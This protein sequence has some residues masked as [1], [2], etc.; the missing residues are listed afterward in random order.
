VPVSATSLDQACDAIESWAA[1]RQGRFVC[2]R[3]VHGVMK[4]LDNVELQH[5]HRD[6]DMITPDGMP[7]V[8]L[9]K[10]RGK[11]I[12]RT[13][14]ADLMEALISRSP[15]SGLKHYFYGG[16]DGV[17]DRLKAVFER[18][19]PGLRVV[20]TECPPFREPTA[21]EK[22]QTIRNIVESGAD[23]V[24][25]GVSTPKQDIWMQKHRDL[26]PATLI[27]VGAA[28]DFHTDRV[29]RAPRWMRDHGLEWLRRLCSEPRRLWRRYLILAPKFALLTLRDIM[30]GKHRHDAGAG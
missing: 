2:V 16:H 29:A 15:D 14:G 25:V 19:Y 21:D 3:D 17:A 24:W 20:G 30:L 1:D 18:R 11:A 28:F 26:L 27:G 23:V 5:A 22:A 8:V 7:L 6:A 10:M 12:S 9:G 4:S 13:A